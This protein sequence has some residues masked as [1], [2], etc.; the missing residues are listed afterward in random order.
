[1][2]GNDLLEPVHDDKDEGEFQT[3]RNRL[4]QGDIVDEKPVQRERL[5]VDN[6]P[7]SCFCVCAAP[8]GAGPVF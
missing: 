7:H 3:T 4:R 8:A 5:F 6:I 1:M 2:N